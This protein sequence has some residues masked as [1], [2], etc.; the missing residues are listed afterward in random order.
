MNNHTNLYLM[1]SVF[2]WHFLYLF[3]NPLI[4]RNSDSL[5]SISV[6][7]DIEI[8]P[9]FDTKHQ[10]NFTYISNLRQLQ[11]P[12]IH[13]QIMLFKNNAKRI[14]TYRHLN[15]QQ[16]NFI[17]FVNRVSYSSRLTRITS[18]TII[19]I[20]K[21]NEKTNICIHLPFVKSIVVM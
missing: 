2:R 5:I 21:T 7:S 8:N 20:K 10:N 1:P 16:I 19:D 15:R 17:C 3:P 13:P 11:Q 4:K 14:N 12:T 18:K 9:V 6:Q